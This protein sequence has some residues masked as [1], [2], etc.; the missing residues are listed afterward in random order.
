MDELF[1]AKVDDELTD[2]D[3]S[4]DDFSESDD[5]TI[6]MPTKNIE[7][8]TEIED[9]IETDDSPNQL[10]SSQR[11]ASLVRCIIDTIRFDEQF[12]HF[13][14]RFPNVWSIKLENTPWK[15]MT[16]KL[17]SDSTRAV[18][19]C[20]ATLV[21]DRDMS[22]QELLKLVDFDAVDPQSF[23]EQNLL[24]ILTDCGLITRSESGEIMPEQ[25]VCSENGDRI[26]YK[27]EHLDNVLRVLYFTIAYNLIPIHHY[28]KEFGGTQRLQRFLPAGADPKH[29]AYT[30][31]LHAECENMPLTLI[32]AIVEYIM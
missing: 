31:L 2:S 29:W 26:V 3:E 7:D 5:E 30:T 23:T 22:Y 11:N 19:E 4:F 25:S 32:E 28:I 21:R 18:D 24:T 15:K 20:I 27:R 17:H 12:K 10:K 16:V 8:A 9:A 6:D 13:S 14:E 1:D